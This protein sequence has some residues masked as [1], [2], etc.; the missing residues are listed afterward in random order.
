MKTI[1]V[2]VIKRKLTSAQRKSKAVQKK[3]GYVKVKTSLAELAA[4]R[5]CASQDD[6]ASESLGAT[7][8]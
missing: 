2:A 8:H 3:T 1:G 4:P 6:L 7:L 5:A